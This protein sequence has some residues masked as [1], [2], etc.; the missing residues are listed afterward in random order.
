[1]IPDFSLSCGTFLNHNP[2]NK[3]AKNNKRML[4]A[5][6]FHF[7]DPAQKEQVKT[8]QDE[9]KLCQPQLSVNKSQMLH[10]FST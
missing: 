8:S 5:A 2:V 4:I 1:M 3:Q 9:S 6:V 10:K 7:V